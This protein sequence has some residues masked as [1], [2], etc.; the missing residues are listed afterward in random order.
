[1]YRVGMG[2]VEAPSLATAYPGVVLVGR[3]SDG[4]VM[5]GGWKE[6]IGEVLAA[7]SVPLRSGRL[8]VQNSL[9][10]S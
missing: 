10:T 5:P 6:W 9:V 1:M 8:V 2:E 3:V 7:G 4:L